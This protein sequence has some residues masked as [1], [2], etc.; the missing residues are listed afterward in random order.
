MILITAFE[1]FGGSQTNT[2]AEVLKRLPDTIS[3]HHI[4]KVLL[5][6]VFGKAASR[7]LQFQADAIFLL[8]EAGRRD[9]VTPERKARNLRD[10]R[11]PDNEGNQPKREAIFPCPASSIGL[12]KDI[13]CIKQRDWEGRPQE[14]D[15]YCTFLP[16]DRIVAQMQDYPISVSEDAGAFVCN[17]TFYLVG[18]QSKVP[19]EF[20]H[21]PAV[22]DQAHV[23]AET[24]KRFIEIALDWSVGPHVAL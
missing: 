12:W 6:V 8:G 23:Y 18:M 9:K 4:E 13:D 21:V 20:I 22:P 11:I 17:D 7:V 16:L 24:V 19:V 10:A 5:P 3:G 1:P 15:Q 2:S 14:F